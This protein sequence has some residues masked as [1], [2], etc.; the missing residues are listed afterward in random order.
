MPLIESQPGALENVYAR[1]LFELALEQGGQSLV[2]SIAGELEDIIELARGD[3]RFNE[4]LASRVLPVKKRDGSLVRI[5]TGAAHPLVLNFLRLLNRKGRLSHLPPI[6][7][8]FDRQLQEHF[9]RI[10]VDV[11]TA[12]P[13]EERQL[14]LIRER[15]AVVLGKQP[16]VHPYTEPAMIGGVKLR[17][18]DQLIDASVAT[19]LR[20]MR[21]RLD[22]RGGAT[23]RGRGADLLDD[24]AH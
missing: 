3:R 17:I 13:I 16:V 15:L 20:Q 21:A 9:G 8:S 6:G 22:E 11:M 19:R 1:S 12:L 23:I 2:E 24:S 18:G 7:A 5:F 4:F 10:E 14:S